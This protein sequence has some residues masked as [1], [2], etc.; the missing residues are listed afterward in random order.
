MAL[1]DSRAAGICTSDF[2]A[3]CIPRAP[4]GRSHRAADIRSCL[5]PFARPRSGNFWPSSGAR[6]P[7]IRHRC[8]MFGHSRT[9]TSL[10]LRPARPTAPP[11]RLGGRLWVPPGHGGPGA[12]CCRLIL[13]QQRGAGGPLGARFSGWQAGRGASAR[14]TKAQATSAFST[15]SHCPLAVASSITRPPHSPHSP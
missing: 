13:A 1:P 11:G 14:S 10:Q 6:R 12:R 5:L 7:E 3:F 8:R 4:A 15:A 2:S 9:V